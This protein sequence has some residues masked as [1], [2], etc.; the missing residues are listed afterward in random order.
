[1]DLEAEY[2]NRARVPEHP[3]HIAAWARDAAAWRAECPRAELNLAYGTEPRQAL[4]LFWPDAGEDAPIAVWIHGGY[5]Q[6]LDRSTSSHCARGLNLRGV[7]VAV[8]SYTLCPQTTLVG[9]L[10]EMRAAMGY[11]HARHGRP[12]LVMGHSAGGHLAAMLAATDWSQFGL[13]GLL[14]PAILPVSGVFELEP[15]L[16]TS[17]ATALHLDAATAH[18]LSPRFLPSPHVACHAVVG[19]AESSEFLRQTREFAAAWHG[20]WEAIPGADH[21]TVTAPFS[22][23]AHPLVARAASMAE[24]LAAS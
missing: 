10:A 8:P 16:T 12:L 1:M 17:I 18:D 6:A 7:A 5:W 23:P 20:S 15:L 21:F 13:P 14:V 11:L 9:I 2:N 3:A 24:A 19:G 22:D 4:D